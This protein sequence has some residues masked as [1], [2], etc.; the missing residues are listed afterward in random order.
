MLPEITLHACCGFLELRRAAP[1][2]TN[3]F[4]PACSV[5]ELIYLSSVKTLIWQHCFLRRIYARE[6]GVSFFEV[7]RTKPV[8]LPLFL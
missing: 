7:A 6:N 1:L 4:R 2:T 5:N 3:A 8:S